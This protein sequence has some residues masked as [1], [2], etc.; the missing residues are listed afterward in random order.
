MKRLALISV[1]F[2]LGAST[3]LAQYGYIGVFSDHG[4]TNCNIV[5]SGSLIT[6]HV[7]HLYPSDAMSSSFS[8]PI[9]ECLTGFTYIN[10]LPSFAQFTGDSQSGITIEYGACISST[11]HLLTVNWVGSGT[12]PECCYIIPAGHSQSAS[13]K[14]EMTDC[15]SQVHL[16]NVSYAIVN[17]TPFCECGQPDNIRPEVSE[18]FPPDSATGVPLNVVLEWETYDPLKPRSQFTMHFGTDPDPPLVS[19]IFHEDT[20]SPGALAPTTTYYW[21]VVAWYLGGGAMSSGPIWSFT[22]MDPSPVKTSTWGAIKAL[23][24]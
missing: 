12:A 3:C 11:V 8:V 7:F 6:I 10:E 23:Y 13:G 21:K 18:P 17:E 2:L 14:A 1:V 22:T 4:A 9:P 20:W 24:R 19:G 16:A 15:E 5:S